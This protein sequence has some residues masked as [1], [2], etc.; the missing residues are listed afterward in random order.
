MKFG[1]SDVAAMKLGAADV[2]RVYL[3]ANL[4][5]EA[6]GGVF[7]PADLFASGEAGYWSPVTAS[8][9]WQDTART[10][11]V[12]ADGDLVASRELTTAS[13]VIYA[14]QANS[15]NR[16]IYKIS[17]GV[18]WLDFTG[19]KFMVTPSI[20]PVANYQIFAALR[21]SSVSG[22]QNILDA[23]YPSPGRRRA[24]YLR[25]NGA[26]P[27]SIG[28]VGGTAYTDVGPAVTI[29][30]DVVLSAIAISGTSLDVRKD[31]TSNG[32]TSQSGTLNTFSDPI[33]IGR[34]ANSATSYYNGRLYGEIVR[35]GA[36]LTSDEIA[37]ATSWC[38]SLM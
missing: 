18:E 33:Y 14:E 3:G 21:P 25:L 12:T 16:P 26:N 15:A 37:D 20:A 35:F 32:T 5:W 31:G 29:N 11:P 8:R 2:S 9:L 27:E 22:G 13:G 30:T 4:V 6:G 10:I 36:N 7:S 38:A 23:D 17:G 1:A 24:Q 19:N 34:Y 28:F